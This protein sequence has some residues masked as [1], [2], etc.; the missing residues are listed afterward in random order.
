MQVTPHVAQKDRG[1]AI[2]GLRTTHPRYGIR[3]TRRKVVEEIFG[4]M[5]TIRLMRARH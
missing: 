1:T 2:H 4:W 3:Q 5:K